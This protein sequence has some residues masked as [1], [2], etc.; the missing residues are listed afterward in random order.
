MTT[1]AGAHDAPP[2]PTTAA[3]RDAAVVST[4]ATASAQRSF[5]SNAT[6]PTPTVARSQC[7]A[8]QPRWLDGVLRLL[9]GDSER[10]AVWRGTRIRGEA[11]AGIGRPGP[12]E[13]LALTCGGAAKSG[14][15][16]TCPSFSGI[17]A[18][19]LGAWC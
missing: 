4:R 16:R 18:T 2:P 17:A 19:G 15:I 6:T 10:P 8:K 14:Q 9:L 3:V 7:L 13:V 1:V 11:Q 12:L 5:S